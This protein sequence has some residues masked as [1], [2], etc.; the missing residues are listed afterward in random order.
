MGLGKL[1]D[2]VSEESV[3]SKVIDTARVE[4]MREAYLNWVAVPEAERGGFTSYWLR[5]NGYGAL[6]KWIM[7][8]E[9][10]NEILKLAGDDVA[11]YFEKHDQ[12][13][14]LT[15][16]SA[17]EALKEAHAI[18]IVSPDKDSTKFNPS[19]LTKHGYKVLTGWLDKKKCWDEAL[20]LAGEVVL[21]DFTTYHRESYSFEIATVEILR[22][23][24]QWSVD[25]VIS[26][27][28]FSPG[29]LISNG[30]EG[31]YLWMLRRKISDEVISACGEIVSKDFEKQEHHSAYTVISASQKIKAAHQK[32][33]S[34]PAGTRGIFNTR[35]LEEN[36]FRPVYAWMLKNKKFDEVLLL[37]GPAVKNDFERKEHAQAYT[38]ES[39]K[40]ALE[41][42]HAQWA[43][44]SESDRGK[45]NRI[46]LLK[47]G[48]SGLAAWIYR[49]NISDVLLGLVDEKISDDFEKQETTT[50]YTVNSAAEKLRAAHAKW[51]NLPE[52]I[53][54]IF[55]AKWLEE[56]GFSYVYEWIVQSKKF[57]EVLLLA[58]PAVKNDF[59]RK[60]HA[61]AYTL[62]S[63]KSALEKA[64]AQWAKISE[65]DRGKFNRNW[66]IKNGYSGLAAW[67]YRTK[68]FDV[69]LDLVD[70]KIS[71]AF[72]KLEITAAYTLNSAAEKLKAAHEEWKL[73]D[74][75][76]RGVFNQ[77]WLNKNGYAG[78][79][80]WIRRSDKMEE[81]FRLVGEEAANDFK[82]RKVSEPYNEQSASIALLNAHA[83]WF[84]DV[85]ADRGRFTSFWLTRNG[86]GGLDNWLN[87]GGRLETVLS[88][89]GDDVSRD[90]EKP[91]KSAPYTYETASESLKKAYERWSEM[92]EADRGIF[93]S[94]WLQKNG[95]QVIYKWFLDRDLFD[96]VIS[97]YPGY[98]PSN[99]AKMAVFNKYIDS[100]RTVENPERAYLDK[101]L[102]LFGSA[103]CVDLLY[104]FKSEFSGIPVESVKG[105]IGQYLGGFVSDRGKFSPA[106]LRDGIPFLAEATFKDGL[107]ETIKDHCLQSYFSERKKGLAHDSSEVIYTYIGELLG[108][109]EGINSPELDSVIE[110]VMCYYNSVLR[111]FHKPEGF[112]DRLDSDREFP[113][114]N[115]RINM[116]ELADKKRLLIAD[117]MGLG[118]SASVIMAK[119]S[120]NVD[121]ALVIAPSN[122][123][124][125]W[126][127]YLSSK[128]GG[129]YQE[130]KEPRVL[131][132][133][134]VEDLVGITADEYD[135]I[136]IS[137][138]RLNG[139]YVGYLMQIDCKMIVVDEVH[140]LKKIDGV[141]GNNILELA[142]SL[143]GDD[144]YLALLSGTP[145]PNKV[146]DIAVVLK[147]LYPEKYADVSTQTLVSQIVNGDVVDIRTE[148]LPRM[149]RKSL[150]DGFELPPLTQETIELDLSDEE[151]E[152][153]EVLL[154]DD[155]LTAT[156][157]IKILRQ[158]LINPELL[159]VTPGL[160]STK[161]K[162]LTKEV[163][164]FF[165]QKNKMV[166]FVNDY[167]EGVIRGEAS[168]LHNLQ[169]PTGVEV[170]VIHGDIDS[171]ERAAIQEEFNHADKKILLIVSGQTADVGVDFSGGEAVLHYNEPWTVYQKMQQLARVHRSGLKNP[172]VES[173]LI[174]RGT[175]EEGIHEYKDVKYRAVEKLLSGIPLSELESELLEN[176]ALSSSDD[177][178]VNADLAEYYFSS[179]DRMMQMFGYVK[180]IGE[181]KLRSFLSEY[182]G[183]YAA[184]YRQLGARSYQANANRVVGTLINDS[185]KKRG[186]KVEEIAI[187]DLCSGP[188]ML[189]RHSASE[190]ADRIVSVDINSE[191][192]DGSRSKNCIVAS[193]AS[194]PFQDES[195]DYV[196]MS[197][198]LH[199]TSFVPSR[200]KLE[201]LKVLM[202]INRV[203]KIGGRV[204]L[205]GIYSL[206]FKD[207]EQTKLAFEE[208]G[209]F[210]VDEY[211]GDAN[212]GNSYSSKVITLE[213]VWGTAPGVS[214]EEMS[215]QL[216][217][218]KREGLKFKKTDKSLKDSRR[219]ITDVVLKD[220]LL[221][222]DLNKS[223]GDILIEEQIIIAEGE[224]LRKKYKEVSAIPVDE[225]I[226]NGFVR[227]LAGKKYILFKKLQSGMG[228]VIV[229]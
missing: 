176:D 46:W 19:W 22:A 228:V 23:H 4:Q 89:A 38:L 78:L 43:K 32:W 143:S 218:D 16:A 82:I 85:S 55:N 181:S 92:P 186:E 101:M 64:H 50:A 10:L 131:V 115:Q 205:N 114:I 130:G 213:K 44:I 56:N 42:A 169:V 188:E 34:L 167:V 31:V 100:L 216:G 142:S 133:G 102:N 24:S 190:Y 149:Q 140:K 88:L 120:L 166:V 194:L 139:K 87:T 148:L 162:A 37:A 128:D 124:A 132:V 65:S 66:L 104:R 201:R 220:E 168:V 224:G 30:F 178:S 105:M 112:V 103:R 146:E 183:E 196:N 59:E 13:A 219:V 164:D 192:F 54:G 48:Y 211:S 116:K 26:D 122:V 6:Y 153:Y 97:Q 135:F 191:H 33:K 51:K 49:I 71:D 113:D 210:I 28:K 137:Q 67:I 175:I 187:L 72:E 5:K 204:V 225:L 90:F 18:W 200:E 214:V 184:C 60:E 193:S 94:R 151:K 159:E 141:R 83:K 20:K 123:I 136:L 226:S 69:L 223:D 150:E 76:E 99:A 29:W 207:F 1:Q 119:E 227:I 58:G 138:E 158:F 62:E 96:Q 160:A 109:I 110:R 14:P 68:I 118:K 93:N 182:G 180:E 197:L 170:R 145:V 206:D 70:E 47:N 77:G 79:F 198:A 91:F 25:R 212:C 177:L 121:C 40:S 161:K 157:K 172:V 117:K 108:Q 106:D 11:T 95:Y 125:T 189:K 12:A 154:E 127:G 27:S 63:A 215:E 203:T 21:K 80:A 8:Y 222:I 111:D 107:Y 129:Y 15:I 171:H 126:K 9:V 195:F 81:V 179:W 36:G 173:T 208:L 74:A 57:D 221:K 202:E 84:A 73:I 53:R 61:Q 45:F 163:H 174:V 185:V 3:E 41:K 147:L 134:S 199:Y 75:Q 7:K 86:F 17:A 35:W 209:F 165:A 2:E 144:S 152:I 52:D 217:K 155:E 156:E 39:A 98:K 229:K